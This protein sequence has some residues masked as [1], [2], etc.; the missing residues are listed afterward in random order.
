MDQL[1][2][3]SEARREAK[4][5]NDQRSPGFPIAVAIAYPPGSWGGH[6]KGWTVSYVPVPSVD[7]PKRR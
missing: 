4:R 7:P 5:Q 1:M 2:S 6:E 3:Q